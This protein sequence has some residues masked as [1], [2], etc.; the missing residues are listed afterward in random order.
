VVQTKRQRGQC[1]EAEGGA[2]R[3]GL[4]IEEV[5]R[6][7]ASSS[8]VSKMAVGVVYPYCRFMS[9]RSLLWVE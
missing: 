9:E 7:D 2:R 5:E 6:E 4:R 3:Y 1:F 8:V